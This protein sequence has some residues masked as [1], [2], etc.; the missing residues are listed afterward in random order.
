M[1]KKVLM[2]G[3]E[4]PPV[5]NG[6]LG[7][8]CLG[9]AK[10]LSEYVDL[11]IILPKTDPE[12]I[13]KNVGLIGLNNID[14]KALL[15]NEKNFVEKIYKGTETTV[16]AYDSFSEAKYI[17]I[18]FDPYYN[19][20]SSEITDTEI[21]HTDIHTQTDHTEKIVREEDKN[22]KQELIIEEF[23]NAFHHGELYGK[24]VIQ[25]VIL[26]SRYVLKMVYERE[27]DIIYAHDWMTFLAGIE[28]KFKTGKPLALHVHALDYDRGGPDSRGWIYDLEKYAMQHADV[29]IPVSKYT[30]DII[31]GH[32]GIDRSKIFPVHNG[33]DVVETYRED[34]AFPEKLVLFLGRVTG[35]KG[36]EFFLEVASKVFEKYKK[37]RFVVAGTGDRLKRLIETGAY[38]QIG[39][40]FHFTGF[41]DKEKVHKLLAMA[42]VYC[43]PSVSE[44]FGLSALEAAQFGIPMVISKQSGAAEVLNGALKADYW[45]V[46]LMAAHITSL[47]ES[48]RLVNKVVKQGYKDL[49]SLSWDHSAGKILTAFNTVMK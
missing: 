15:Q 40:K 11:T 25:K 9:I 5:I 10:S 6:G 3:W 23:L 8:A 32:Y 49:E 31:E 7:V 42:D 22:L 24:D 21:K 43:M 35:Q 18:N 16:T 17:N 39:H 26:Y 28:V 2:L 37:V 46:D 45:D 30:G 1:K 29:I 48:K 47:L 33:V 38:R 20:S 27:F 14:L 41:L 12:F 4:F 44:P 34:K 19:L 36:P 13:V